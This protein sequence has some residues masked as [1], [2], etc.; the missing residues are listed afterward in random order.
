MILAMIMGVGLFLTFIIADIGKAHEVRT[1]KDVAAE[2]V[3]GLKTAEAVY[4]AEVVELPQDVVTPLVWTD[5]RD[6]IAEIVENFDKNDS[7]LAVIVAPEADETGRNASSEE[8]WFI[9]EG[10]ATAGQAAEVL[11][12]AERINP[13]PGRFLS[14]DNWCQEYGLWD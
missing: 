10:H 14:F 8:C 11:L 3:T 6:R 13:E 1:Q 9:S 5:H 12:S 2:Y 4:A 7:P